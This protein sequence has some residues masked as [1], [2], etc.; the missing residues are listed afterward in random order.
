MQAASASDGVRPIEMRRDPAAL[1]TV[2]PGPRRQMPGDHS[3]SLREK[4][5]ADR[6]IAT[7]G[8]ERR[9]PMAGDEDTFTDIVDYILRCTHR[10]WEEKAIGYLYEHYAANARVFQD[11]GIVYGR[12]RVIADTAR[13][14]AGFPDLR[15]H[16]D[17]IVCAATRT[18]A[19]GPR[20]GSH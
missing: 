19:S 12:E 1:G 9:Q 13:A 4:R 10:I 15:L 7:P 11:D 8:G 2:T 16:A 20:T 18:P 17:E 14:I 6:L 5:A 3:I